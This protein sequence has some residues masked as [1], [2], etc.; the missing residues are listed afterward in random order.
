MVSWRHRDA[1]ATNS[2][3]PVEFLAP[4]LVAGGNPREVF[5]GIQGSIDDANEHL[6][7][8]SWP[9]S[10]E[11]PPLRRGRS[12][13]EVLRLRQEGCL[14]CGQLPPV[15]QDAFGLPD[16]SGGECVLPG[17]RSLD[18][19]A[20]RS[21]IDQAPGFLAGQGDPPARAQTEL[22]HRATTAG[23]RLARVADQILQNAG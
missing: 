15:H 11:E 14:R 21:S 23:A 1:D 20:N 22:D 10:T 16:T 9:P 7:W 8:L 4:A 13:P 18:A 6:D 12:C 3:T 19:L 2:V 17:Q 5:A